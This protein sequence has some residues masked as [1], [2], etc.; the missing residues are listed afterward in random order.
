MN[1]IFIPP[2]KYGINKGYYTINKIINI[3]RSKNKDPK[4]AFIL[5]MLEI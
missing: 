4:T 5:D 1:K 2:N 3:I